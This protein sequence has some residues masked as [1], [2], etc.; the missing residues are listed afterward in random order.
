MK[1]V[2]TGGAGYIGSHTCKALARAGHQPIAVDNL[3]TGHREA[4]KWGPLHVVDI[5]DGA[6]LAPVL[7]QIAPDAIIHLAASAIVKDSMSDPFG[8]FDNNVRGTL[9]LLQ[10]AMRAGTRFV[11]FSSSCATYGIPPDLPI[12]EDMPQRPSNPY[13]ETKLVCE[14]LLRWTEAAFGTKWVALRYFN[15]AGADPDGEIGEMHAD[16]THLIPLVLRAAA[17]GADPLLVFGTDHA[18]ADGTALRDYVH[19]SDVAEA[20]LIAL[21]YLASGGSSDAFNLGA[22]TP[23][24]VRDIVRVVENTLGRVVPSRDMPRRPGDPPAL[25]ADATRARDTLGWSARH[26]SIDEIIRSAWN[27][28]QR[29]GGGNP[30]QAQQVAG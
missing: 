10:A 8:Y 22:G 9:S 3:I 30:W 4:V 19:V 21:K 12:T 27:W 7:A 6:A 24:S 18:T 20:H 11:V 26:S 1:V 5:R 28:E 16:E 17:G 14:K 2:V 15:V 29:V 25:W 23:M 13:G